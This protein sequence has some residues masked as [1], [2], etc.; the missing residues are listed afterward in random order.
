MKA[1]LVLVA[2]AVATPAQARRTFDRCSLAREMDRMGVPRSQLDKW[3]CIAQ[4]E[5]DYRTWVKGPPNSD[6]SVDY[7]I[8]QINDRYWCKAH[9]RQSPNVCGVSC[10][11]LLSDDIT[12]S[13]RCA[14]KVLSHQT[15]SAWATW[16]FCNGWLP[17]I[18]ECFQSNHLIF[19]GIKSYF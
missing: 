18:D 1:F 11:A 9:G 2:L 19:D 7:G 5:S 15:W 14:R 3:T 10:D 13:V 17:S 16:E 12:E 4:R 8:F 6:G